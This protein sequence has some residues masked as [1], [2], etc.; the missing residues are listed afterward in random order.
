L[1][2][3]GPGCKEITACLRS[4][5]MMVVSAGNYGEYHS[6]FAESQFREVTVTDPANARGAL[7]VGACA[8]DDPEYE[9]ICS[10]SSHGP[11]ADGRVKPDIVAPGMDIE[12]CS[13]N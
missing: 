10:F 4:G 8:T 6:Q 13:D 2:G 12:S 1:V 3:Y 9:G 7:V 11:T 5:Q